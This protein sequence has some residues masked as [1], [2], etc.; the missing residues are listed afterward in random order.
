M[1]WS[2]WSE[3]CAWA[4]SVS[5]PWSRLLRDPQPF[6]MSLEQTPTICTPEGNIITAQETEQ[7]TSALC[8]AGRLKDKGEALFC[9]ETDASLSVPCSR[10]DLC[11]PCPLVSCPPEEL[12]S[13]FK[14]LSPDLPPF[15]LCDSFSILS[16]PKKSHIFIFVFPLWAVGLLTQ[17]RVPGGPMHCLM[18][19]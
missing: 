8:S 2:D 10:G 6:T 3:C 18:P 13:S 1:T 7:W 19:L 11:F 9:E 14:A 12:F 16:G 17:L 5:L 4:R 15:Y